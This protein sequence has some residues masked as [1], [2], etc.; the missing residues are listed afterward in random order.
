MSLLNAREMQINFVH[1]N[2][3][4]IKKTQQTKAAKPTS[5][6]INSG[7]CCKIFRKTWKWKEKVCLM[8]RETSTGSS[9]PGAL[10]EYFLHW[11]YKICFY[12]HFHSAQ[13]SHFCV[14]FWDL[15][16]SLV[17]YLCSYFPKLMPLF[18]FSLLKSAFQL[19]V[20]L[21]SLSFSWGQQ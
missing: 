17:P 3:N 20:F 7:N 2:K 4:L 9:Q 12:F 16:I 13:V 21:L 18:S 6:Y 8:D 19:H 1:S 5:N 14:I 11:F 10:Q 15:L